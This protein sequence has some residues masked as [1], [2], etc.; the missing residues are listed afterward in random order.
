MDL[1]ASLNQ[2]EAILSVP[3]AQE[4]QLLHREGTRAKERPIPHLSSPH[5]ELFLCSSARKM[6]AWCGDRLVEEN[7]RELEFCGRHM[8][9]VFLLGKCQTDPGYTVPLCL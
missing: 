1:V 8:I 5:K 4:S 9:V 3:I 7:L 6:V 2:P